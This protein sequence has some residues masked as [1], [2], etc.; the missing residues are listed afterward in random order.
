MCVWQD[1][2]GAERQLT[3]GDVKNGVSLHHALAMRAADY[4]KRPNVFY[5]RTADWRVFLMQAP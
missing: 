5:L 4:A 3:E 1:E 2:Y